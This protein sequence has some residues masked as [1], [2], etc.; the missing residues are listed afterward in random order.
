MKIFT[1]LL[2]CLSTTCIAETPFSKAKELLETSFNTPI[3]PFATQDF[4]RSKVASAISVIIPE[5]DHKQALFTLREK[6]PDGVIAY[7][8]TTRNLS[9]D[10]IQG[11]ELVIINSND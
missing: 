4:G 7:I 3:R 8:G 11:V 10:S 6:L 5:Q 1:I 9:A 2:L